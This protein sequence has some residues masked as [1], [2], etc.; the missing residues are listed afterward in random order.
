M[1]DEPVRPTRPAPTPE[2]RKP[3]RPA[4]IANALTSVAQAVT[5]VV[6]TIADAVVGDE[7]AR[8]RKPKPIGDMGLA[9]GPVGEWAHLYD[10]DGNYVPPK[11]PSFKRTKRAPT[12]F[13]PGAFDVQVHKRASDYGLY[14]YTIADTQTEAIRKAEAFGET[15][16]LAALPYGREQIPFYALAYLHAYY[17]NANTPEEDIHMMKLFDM[18]EAFDRKHGKRMNNYEFQRAQKAQS[19]PATTVSSTADAVAR[20]FGESMTTEIEEEGK[21][22][23]DYTRHKRDKLEEKQR[24]QRPDWAKFMVDNDMRITLD[25]YVDAENLAIED[26]R[27][28]YDDYP[29]EDDPEFQRMVLMR[30]RWSTYTADTDEYVLYSVFTEA[31]KHATRMFQEKWGDELKADFDDS[32]FLQYFRDYVNMATGK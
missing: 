28:R 29:E 7:W 32:D 13:D 22:I 12:P 11:D 23:A 1:N 19:A 16:N 30:A 9:L 20:Y 21:A 3:T 15:T 17:D 14:L 4:P 27:D 6:A 10:E 2:P 26:F 8:T 24:I 25:E 5:G 18:D 31:Y